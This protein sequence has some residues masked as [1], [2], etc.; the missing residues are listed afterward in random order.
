MT[1]TQTPNTP[2][3]EDEP[4]QFRRIVASAIENTKRQIEEQKAERSREREALARI[5]LVTFA[6]S[7]LLP[8]DT[9]ALILSG[10]PPPPEEI[11]TEMLIGAMN[12]IDKSGKTRR[13]KRTVRECVIR[14]FMS[15]ITSIDVRVERGK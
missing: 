6:Y 10:D 9:A 1:E 14:A 15:A 13:E 2:M 11:V 5:N 3:R 4:A 12:A 8:G 7:G